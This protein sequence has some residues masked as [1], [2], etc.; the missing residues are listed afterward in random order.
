MSPSKLGCAAR[1]FKKTLLKWIEEDSFEHASALSFATLFSM[2]PTLVIIIGLCAIFFGQEAV[3]GRIF[4]EIRNL[5]GAEGADAI[6]RIL[7]QAAEGRKATATAFGIVLTVA[8]ASAAFSQMKSALNRIWD[9]RPEP[10]VNDLL[11]F[12]RT[13]LLSLAMVLVIGFLLLVSLAVSASLAAFGG[14]I[15]AYASIPEW[16]LSAFNALLSVAVVTVLF[17]MIFKVL[18]DVQLRWREVFLGAL[19]TSIL[20]SAG[21]GLIGMYIGKSGVTSVFGAA[22]SLVIVMLWVYYSSLILFLGAAFIRVYLEERGHRV[23]PAPHTVFV[24]EETYLPDRP[25]L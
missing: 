8:G 20:F 13:R 19:F 5:V 21:K 11:Y 23:W 14:A 15:A 1:I 4:F 22:G 9:V 12:L 25:A 6:Q 16:A 24:R 7:R 3:E 2:A 10:A 18:P 17:A